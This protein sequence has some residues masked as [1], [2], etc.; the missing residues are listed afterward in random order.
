[1][2][3]NTNYCFEFELIFSDYYTFLGNCPPTPPLSQH[4]H[5]LLT[6]GKTLVQGRGRWAVS[7]SAF[8]K[9]LVSAVDYNT[10]EIRFQK[11]L[12]QGVLSNVCH[13]EMTTVS[14]T[15]FKRPQRNECARNTG[16]DSDLVTCNRQTTLAPSLS[17]GIYA[18]SINFTIDYTSIRRTVR[19]D[20]YF[21]LLLLFDS[22]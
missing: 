6:Q 1:M 2:Y 20:P 19:I 18:W 15:V 10:T 16:T 12:L 9:L 21:S 7:Q 5:L 22:Q 3:P 11:Y 8:S 4:K 13:F 17:D 14:E